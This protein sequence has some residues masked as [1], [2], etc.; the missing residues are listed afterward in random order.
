MKVINIQIT[1]LSQITKEEL[2]LLSYG[3][4]IA[5]GNFTVRYRAGKPVAIE[6]AMKTYNLEAEA[7]S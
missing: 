6:Q 3:R 2:I 1:D 4:S 7:K 5:Y